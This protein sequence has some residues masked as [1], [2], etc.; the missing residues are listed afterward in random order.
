[1]KLIGGQN[2]ILNP[3]ELDI[4]FVKVQTRYDG[5]GRDD[6]GEEV[7]QLSEEGYA[8]LAIGNTYTWDDKSKKNI[9][10]MIGVF[11]R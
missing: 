6:W 5:T 7:N 4:K 3:N 11:A 10:T 2:M 9:C 8:C 1:M